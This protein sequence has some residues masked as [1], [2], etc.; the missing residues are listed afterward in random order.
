M[1]CKR[2]AKKSLKKEKS[3]DMFPE[4]QRQIQCELCKTQ[5]SPRLCNTPD[6]ATTEYN[7][8]NSPHAIYGCISTSL[9][10]TKKGHPDSLIC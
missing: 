6:V 5:P 4:E 1:L 2:F 7:L 8:K 10:K 9:A 3:K